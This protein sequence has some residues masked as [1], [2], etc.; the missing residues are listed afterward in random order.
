MATTGAAVAFLVMAASMAQAQSQDYRYSRTSKRIG[1]DWL[2]GEATASAV[3]SRAGAR[4][5]YGEA[6][7]EA[8]TMFAGDQRTIIKASVQ[9][10]AYPSYASATAAL[11]VFNKT[12]QYSR[13]TG[14]PRH[15]EWNK[16]FFLV[17]GPEKPYKKL[18]V[19]CCLP[20]WI[21]LQAGAGIATRLGVEALSG[22]NPT[23][24]IG[25]SASAWAFVTVKGYVG[26]SVGGW[27]VEVGIRAQFKLLHTSLVASATP[28]SRSF[29]GSI[30]LDLVGVTITVD[31][32]ATL[33]FR[34]K[35]VHTHRRK[36]RIIFETYWKEEK[37]EK[38]YPLYA[39]SCGFERRNLMTF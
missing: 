25:G 28:T 5:V 24:R 33:T 13:S 15:I 19:V 38:T 31:A 10:V 12:T 35:W 36:W 32:Y 34:Y 37:T 8:Y 16:T 3:M 11:V 27:S 30:Y 4:Y 22:A 23:L 17:G 6:T 20:V 18:F 7:G 2:Y 1:K 14:K 39:Y 9:G 29:H 21:E 26:G